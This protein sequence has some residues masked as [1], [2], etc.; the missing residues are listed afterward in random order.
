MAFSEHQ[1]LF[2]HPLDRVATICRLVA[3]YVH[4]HNHVLPDSAF[5]GQTPN[6]RYFGTG[7]RGAGGPD[8]TRG[9][10]A[11][12]TRG[13]QPVGI[14]RDVPVTQRR[15]VTQAADRRC[16]REL[17]CLEVI[18]E[19][20]RPRASY[21]GARTSSGI[22]SLFVDRL[23]LAELNGENSR[24]EVQNVRGESSA[25]CPSCSGWRMAER[26]AHLV[27]D[28][29]PLVQLTAE[30]Q[31]ILDLRHR[32]ADGTTQLLFDAGGAARA[33][34]CADAAPTDQSPD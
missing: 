10:R 11:P 2:L 6:E 26:A 31:V 33:A 16:A 8:L 15:R 29:F 25:V 21:E 19:R 22:R 27:D 20:T 18:A 4:E 34:G 7:G 32:W 17:V 3:F 30:R 1:W 23:C 24:A 14:L 12:G 5:R 28:V 13:G 9:C